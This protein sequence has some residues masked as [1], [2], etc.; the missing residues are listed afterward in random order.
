MACGLWYESEGTLRKR[1]FSSGNFWWAFCAHINRLPSPVRAATGRVPVIRVTLSGSGLVAGLL[2]GPALAAARCIQ[3]AGLGK[4]S[5]TRRQQVQLV[6][7]LHPPQLWRNRRDAQALQGRVYW[8]K[9]TPKQ[10][11]TGLYQPLCQQL[12]ERTMK[13]SRI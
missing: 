4:E 9:F 10:N 13:L 3:V 12:C 5:T 2:P 11:W 1:H 7:R 8:P 6:C